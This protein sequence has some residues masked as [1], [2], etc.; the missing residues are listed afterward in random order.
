[1]LTAITKLSEVRA[2]LKRFYA[3]LKRGRSVL[4]TL[5][6]QGHTTNEY[7][8]HWHHK[9]GLWAVLDAGEDGNRS[10]NCFGTSD[11]TEGSGTIGIS[12]EINI[13]HEGMNRKIAGV[14][15]KDASGKEYIAHTGKI[16]GG[17][18][19]ISKAHFVA[20]FPA[21]DQWEDVYWPGVRHPL[22]C[23]VISALDD[24]ALVERIHAFVRAVEDFKNAKSVKDV[25]ADGFNPEFS[26]ERAPYTVSTEI[27]ARCDHG[28]II[29][30]LE[31]ELRAELTGSRI[32]VTNNK[33]NDLVLVDAR[34][35]QLALFEA[36]TSAGLTDI[37][38][39]IGQLL[40]HTADMRSPC[41][42]VAVLPADLPAESLTRLKRLDLQVCTYR[43]ERR[44]PI[45]PDLYR[46][47]RRILPQE[48]P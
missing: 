43:W 37:Y 30:A 24:P 9:P 48:R 4:R 40:Y 41:A 22:P 38:S 23:I 10:W 39:A 28:R 2:S 32:L 35:R 12:C 46:L 34:Q 36:K 45:F 47:L 18:K 31:S 3:P 17:R 5:G 7:E 15:A 16:G 1:M 27:N 26:G 8:V 13:P 44:K 11:P 33:Y 6:M 25:K 14:F 42:R 19:G 20:S 29:N 21:T